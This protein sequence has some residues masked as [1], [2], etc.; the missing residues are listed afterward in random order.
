M[1]TSHLR[2]KDQT[3]KRSF[4][5]ITR[6]LTFKGKHLSVEKKSF[7]ETREWQTENKQTLHDTT[8]VKTFDQ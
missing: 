8:Q 5:Y 6:P 2:I 1:P 4:V 7:D 3:L